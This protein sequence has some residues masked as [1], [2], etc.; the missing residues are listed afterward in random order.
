VGR[1]GPA[2]LGV[3]VAFDG[4]QRQL[5]PPRLTSLREALRPR[6]A[7]LDAALEETAAWASPAE[8]ADFAEA[9]LAS[10]RHAARGTELFLGEQADSAGAGSGI[11][12][13]MAALHAH[14]R[15]QA[16]VFPLRAILPAFDRYFLEAESRGVP[17]APVQA[18]GARAGVFNASNEPN[19]RGGFSLFVPEDYDEV[20]SWPLVVALHGGFGHGGDFLWTWLREAR[21]RGW[22]LLAPTAQAN[23]WS[24]NGPD[25]DGPALESMLDYVEERWHVDARCR[26]LTGLSDGGTYALLHGLREA[27][28][29][30]ALAPVAGVLHPE[31]FNN[32][33]LGRAAGRRIRWIHGALD[34]MFPVQMAREGASVL[35][36]AGADLDWVEIA[37]LSHA[38]PREQ[39]TSL[40]DWAQAGPESG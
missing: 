15:A 6:A 10:A 12:G 4:I 20:K 2:L 34:W 25:R 17:L 24:M 8:L 33:N 28:R 21:T 11:E 19:Q 23:T 14:C 39:N 7:R 35:E 22:L 18:P 31:N 30:T 3:L 9:L 38:Y 36:D 27:S 16:T 37:D 26:L 13:V 40:L 5:H 1:L 29:F 32:G